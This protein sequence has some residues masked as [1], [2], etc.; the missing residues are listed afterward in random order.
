MTNN[1]N[2]PKLEYI[3][4]LTDWKVVPNGSGYI[5]LGNV[6]GDIQKRFR[7]G[8]LIYTSQVEFLNL[9]D[10]WVK[11]LNSLYKLEE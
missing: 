3:A 11:T 9:K 4:T 2:K 7:D 1:I 6:N 10:G 8:E 5:V